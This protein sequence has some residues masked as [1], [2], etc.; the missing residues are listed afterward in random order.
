MVV[1]GVVRGVFYTVVANQRQ[2]QQGEGGGGERY[3]GG[4]GEGL[5]RGGGGGIGEVWEVE[6]GETG[7]DDRVNG[8]GWGFVKGRVR[9]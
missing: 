7:G 6:E 3:V 9:W 1:A 2:P 5:E 8:G 4:S